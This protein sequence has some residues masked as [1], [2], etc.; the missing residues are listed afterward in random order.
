MLTA[1]VLAVAVHGVGGG[2]QVLAMGV[3]SGGR[4]CVGVSSDYVSVGGGV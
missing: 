1:Q 2:A 3:P 4:G